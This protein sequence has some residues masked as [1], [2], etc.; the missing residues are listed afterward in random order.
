MYVYYIYN[1]YTYILYIYP[2]RYIY[3]LGIKVRN[4]YNYLVVRYMYLIY[5]RISKCAK[6]IIYDSDE[7]YM[8]VLYTLFVTLQ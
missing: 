2:P 4:V 6:M 3:N 5:K 7:E 1:I 8:G